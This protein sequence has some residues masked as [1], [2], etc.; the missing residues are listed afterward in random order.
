MDHERILCAGFGGQGVMTLGK[1]LACAAMLE[2]REVTWLPS[3]GPEMRGGTA[4]CC[5][6]ISSAPVGSP[7][8]VRDATCLIVMNQPSLVKFE[9]SLVSGG[10]GKW[11]RHVSYRLLS[12]AYTA[13]DQD[14]RSRS[15][16]I[17]CAQTGLCLAAGGSRTTRDSKGTW[18]PGW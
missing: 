3:Y 14:R 9:C 6:V 13:H 2:G 16:S 11:A 12:G 18:P 17:F 15:V 5:V 10:L 8:T 7:V 4:Y 1:L